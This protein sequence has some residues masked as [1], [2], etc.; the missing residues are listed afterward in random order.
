MRRVSSTA[1]FG[2]MQAKWI[3]VTLLSVI[4][5]LVSEFVWYFSVS[6]SSFNTSKCN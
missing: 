4:A 2:L 5:F 6:L 3:G 1:V